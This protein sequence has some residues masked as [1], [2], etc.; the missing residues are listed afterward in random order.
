[1]FGKRH[2]LNDV[3]IEVKPG[4][5]IAITGKSGTGKTT[6]LGIVSGLLKPGKGRVSFQNRNI[7]RWTDFTR[8]RF[9][10]RKIGFV[11]QFF[12]LLPD[13]TCYQ[14]I[15][16]P[17]LLN[18]FSRSVRK[19]ADE[20]ISFLGLSEI[21]NQYPATLS[22]GER[23][24]VAIAR[25]IINHPA[26]IL[27]DEPTGNLDDLS[28]LDII[29]L[30]K[31]LREEQNIAFVIVT[32]DSRIV[33]IADRHYH[34]SGGVLNDMTVPTKDAQTSVKAAKKSTEKKGVKKTE[35]AGRSKKAN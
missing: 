19:R 22:G 23:Q 1:M 31:R 33:G 5:I 2:I 24:R 11:F 14:N 26:M 4:Q 28:A 29:S 7:F 9:R 25:A 17:A 15:V 30:F 18:P 13:M 35:K 27:A 34:L 32:H 3:S 21:R 6:L 10:N 12:N 8:S 20:L 16:Y